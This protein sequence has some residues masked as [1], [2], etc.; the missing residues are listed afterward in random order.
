MK[1]D[2]LA[3]L[4]AGDIRHAIITGTLK[5][6][7]RLPAEPDMIEQ[8]GVSRGVVREALRLLEA[9]QLVEVRRGPKG[10][11]II[12][13][14]N[15][16]SIDRAALL[17]MRLQ[18]ST[19]GDLYE[20]TKVLVP[21]SAR[22]ASQFNRVQAVQVLSE[23]LGVVRQVLH[24]DEAQMAEVL[25]NFNY[26]IIDNCGVSTLQIVGQSLHRII[27]G[28]LRRLHWIF[29]PRLGNTD[30]ADF[31]GTSIANADILIHLIERGAG[32]AAE[33][34]W[35]EHMERTGQIYFGVVDASTTLE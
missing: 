29:K 5:Q 27:G 11:A 18:Q 25:S 26:L 30:Y 20:T 24:E 8:Y 10:G 32:A 7:D 21:A 6:G 22:L 3:D 33:V 9:D 23:A 15:H 12:T 1:T 13:P 28:Q 2:K 14:R 31:I 17:S 35:R 34:H 4:V 19:I 16:E